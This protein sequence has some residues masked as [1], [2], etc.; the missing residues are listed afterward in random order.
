MEICLNK[1][2]KYTDE[3]ALY[4][5]PLFNIGFSMNFTIKLQFEF[6]RH[7]YAPSLLGITGESSDLSEDFIDKLIHNLE[8]SDTMIVFYSLIPIDRKSECFKAEPVYELCEDSTYVFNALKKL[9]SS[10][11][12]INSDRWKYEDGN[13]G[14]IMT[15]VHKAIPD[16]FKIMADY[17]NKS[18]NIY[19]EALN[20]I[21]NSDEDE[22]YI[23]IIKD[24][25]KEIIDSYNDMLEDIEYELDVYGSIH[26]LEKLYKELMDIY[27]V[28]YYH[29]LATCSYLI[30]ERQPLGK[31]MMQKLSK[32]TKVFNASDKLLDNKAIEGITSIM[33]PTKLLF[34]IP[35]DAN[36]EE[37][38]EN[39]IEDITFN[40]ILAC[41]HKEYSMSVQNRPIYLFTNMNA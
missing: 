28:G 36:L 10:C 2:I 16:V 39:T 15:L 6:S 31:I 12:H 18:D 41:A 29:R 9:A 32:D 35:S 5:K 1:P 19:R 37:E 8:N 24:F 14:P 30:Y 13:K 21:A 3:E 7:G 20:N 11:Y 22:E 4:Y 26:Y 17:T 27:L 40:Y 23:D 34:Q 33:R 38:A 25:F